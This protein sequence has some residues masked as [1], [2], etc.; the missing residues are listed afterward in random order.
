MG[1]FGNK[2][3]KAREKKGVSLDDASNVTKIGARMLQ[4]IEEEQFDQLPGGVFNKG[5]IRA[6]AK[7]LGINDQEAVTEYLDCLSQEQVRAQAVWEPQSRPATPPKRPVTA[8]NVRPVKS[9]PAPAVQ[10]EELPDLQLPRAEHVRP[11]H[12]KYLGRERE[13]G[14]PWRLIVATLVVFLLATVLW[15]RHAIGNAAARPMA[16]APVSTSQSTP[17]Q[18]S[19]ATQNAAAATKTSGASS[20]NSGNASNSPT[21]SA[22][23]AGSNPTGSNAKSSNG[24]ASNAAATKPAGNGSDVDENEVITRSFVNTPAMPSDK[25]AVPFM[26]VIRANENSWISV[27]ADGKTVSQETLIAPAHASIRASREIVAKVGNAAGVSF[28]WNGKEIPADGAES[29]TKT[30]V[31]DAQGMRVVPATQPANQNP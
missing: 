29:E 12:Q 31:F 27:S 24:S 10:T 5:F 21:Q 14:I 26:L 1:D 8:A 2:F 4:A 20:G 23:P 22:A 17:A 19:A 15:R 7:Y 16:S 13:S 6:Y 11:P 25:P 28:S 9:P 30:F 18:E 3:R